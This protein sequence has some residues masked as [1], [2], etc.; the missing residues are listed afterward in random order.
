M[1]NGKWCHRC[2][3]QPVDPN[4]IIHDHAADIARHIDM[5]VMATV[6]GWM[7]ED[8]GYSIGTQEKYEEF[9]RMRNKTIAVDPW[10]WTVE[11]LKGLR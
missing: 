7:D 4:K 3:R 11:Q 1:E 2:G 8:K 9:V 10:T 6:G 5:Q